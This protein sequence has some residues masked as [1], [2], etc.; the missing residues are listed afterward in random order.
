MAAVLADKAG[1][2]QL[3]V[4][5]AQVGAQLAAGVRPEL[6][7]LMQVGV[8]VCA[9]EGGGAAEGWVLCGGMTQICCRVQSHGIVIVC[10]NWSGHA[11]LRPWYH[12]VVGAGFTW[13]R[14]TSPPH[15][16]I[17]P[18]PSHH[19]APVHPPL[20][21]PLPPPRSLQVP[22]MHGEQA[23][24]LHA[25]G[26]VRPDLVAAAPAQEVVAALAA[27]GKRPAATGAAR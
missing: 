11:A 5:L 8:G 9:G 2:W 16:Y 4:A 17:L 21:C 10:F 13:V 26:L 6:L 19:P 1:Y 18:A 25:A 15:M 20:P 27:G 23:R 12:C 7:P 14:V 22:G 3:E 24:R